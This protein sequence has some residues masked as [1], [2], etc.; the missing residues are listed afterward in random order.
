MI[1]YQNFTTNVQS[2][3]LVPVDLPLVLSPFLSPGVRA[4]EAFP[5]QNS[6]TIYRSDGKFL[7]TYGIRTAAAAL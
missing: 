2:R 1:P 4:L 3:L 7:L 6:G 5:T